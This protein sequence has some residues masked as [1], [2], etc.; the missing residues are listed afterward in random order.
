MRTVAFVSALGGVGCTTLVAHSAALLAE[1]GHPVVALELSAQN[2]LGLYLGMREQPPTGWHSTVQAGGWLG[3]AALEN[4]DG[5]RLLA[6]GPC[7]APLPLAAPW[8]AQQLQA[9]DVP[10]PTVVL[11]DTPPLPAPLAQQA[12]ACA[13][14]VLVVLDAAWRSVYL[15]ASL[16]ALLAGLQPH[17]RV[18]MVVTGVDPRSPSH[19]DALAQLPRPRRRACAYTRWPPTPKPP[20]TCKA[21][22]TGWNRPWPS[23]RWCGPQEVFDG[24]TVRPCMAAPGAGGA[25][26]RPVVAVGVAGLGTAPRAAPPGVAAAGLVGAAYCYSIKSCFRCF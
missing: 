7:A 23:C 8:L 18:G 4:A 3:D 25:T 14:V 2:T 11:L 1:R 17:Q 13:D 20:T 21:L 12:L 15:H 22:P 10:D 16:Q 6:H 9:L 19:R 24:A 5:V 26:G